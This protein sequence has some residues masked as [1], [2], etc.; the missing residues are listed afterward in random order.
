[1]S[2]A[3]EELAKLSKREK[4]AL[5]AIA[6][7]ANTWSAVRRYVEEATG[8]TLP[9]ATTSRII[10]KLEALGLV[11]D[12]KFLDPVYQEAAKRL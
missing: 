6:N 11:K 7:G 3:L 2:L 9:K 12:F 10:D 5:K 1:M 4:L 8:E